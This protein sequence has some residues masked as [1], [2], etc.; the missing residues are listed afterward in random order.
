MKNREIK[1]LKEFNDYI[2]DGYSVIDCYGEFCGACEL[3]EP[4]LNQAISEMAC[5]HFGKV[6]VSLY[7]EIAE[8]YSIYAMPTLLFFYEGKEVHRISGSMDRE[9]LNE[10]FSI[11]LYQ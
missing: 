2:K 10:Q 4:V 6:N 1:D 11:M 3:L 5:I 9:T 7:P 8:K